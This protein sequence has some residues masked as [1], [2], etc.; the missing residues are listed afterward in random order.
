M[1]KQDMIVDR[2]TGIITNDSQNKHKK[3]ENSYKNYV[4]YQKYIEKSKDDNRTQKH[5]SDVIRNK[6]E[7]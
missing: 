7:L 4:E 2:F 6:K 1:K 3:E 5:Q